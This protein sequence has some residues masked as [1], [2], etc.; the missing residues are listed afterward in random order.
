M[1]LSGT[2][3]AEVAIIG[4]GVAGL[5]TALNL[6]RLG[7]RPIL[8]EA[9]QVA[10]VATGTSA[11]IVAPQLVRNTPASVRTKLGADPGDRLLSMLAQ[12][13]D[14]LFELA[15]EVA[16][17]S[18]P[19]QSGFIAPAMGR[20]GLAKLQASAEEWGRYRSDMTILDAAET[21]RMTGVHGYAG[22][23]LDRSGGSINPVVYGQG[24]AKAAVEAGVRL[25]TQCAARSLSRHDGQWSIATDDG[26]IRARRVV[27][28]ANAANGDLHP[29]LRGTTL[30]LVVCE[31][32]TAPLD[33]DLRTSILPG[34]QSLTDV[35]ADVFSIRH[36]G[37]GGLVTA[38]PAGS[39][40]D[41]ETVTRAINTRLAA[42]IPAWKPLPLTHIWRGTAAV[43]SSLL[44][45]LVR[46]EEDLYAV[47]ACNGRGL[48][49]NTVLGRD[50]A[51]WLDAPGATPPPLP[52]ERPSRISGF[53]LAKHAP[54]L[55]M[56]AALLG[57]RVQQFVAGSRRPAQ[58]RD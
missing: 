31:V 43:N 37:G 20:S 33:P 38:Y 50:L 28:C 39:E 29:A 17:D 26:T 47:Q 7:H 58:D 12:A 44:P 49:L 19:S 41:D 21:E 42:A 57:K 1:R 16:P 48:A 4:A 5:V 53:L 46:V 6:A 8:L 55:I 40:V 27:L 10:R 14:Y 2:D 24:L 25:Y 36:H 45:R 18:E 30:P 23:V 15:R 9:G 54:K 22:A 51:R 32:A 52:L 34:G 35:E 56:T 13:G 11:G 3:D